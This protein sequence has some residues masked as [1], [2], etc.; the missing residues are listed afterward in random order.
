MSRIGK[1][2]ILISEGVQVEIGQGSVKITG[3]KG[4]L[5]RKISPEIKAEVK[6]GKILLAP[7]QETKKG[8]ALW[9][10]TRS[11]LFNMVKGVK[12]GYEKKLQIEGV[13]FRAAIEAED[14]VLQLGFS[15]PVRIK[16]PGQIKFSVEKNIITISGI[17]KE[18]VGETAA[19]IR[20]LR[21]PEPY[22]GKGI[23]Y[24]GEWV[25]KKAGKKVVTAAT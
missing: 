5:Q 19:R 6:D 1:K 7:L 2:P 14:L 23:R 16:A 12:E 25:R 24:F 9:G 11:L 15:H 21:K 10:L 8:R 4:E 3:P 20:R 22:K 13:G 18:L 17:D